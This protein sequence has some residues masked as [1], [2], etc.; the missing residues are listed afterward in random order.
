MS[1]AIAPID[2]GVARTGLWARRKWEILR[3]AS[4]VALVVLWQLGSAIGVISQDVLPAP[5]LIAEA[6]AN[7][8]ATGSSSTP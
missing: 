5:S 2:T 6:G 4:P 3:V 8:W 7:C 1:I